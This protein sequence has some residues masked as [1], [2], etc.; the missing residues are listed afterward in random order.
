MELDFILALYFKSG[1]VRFIVENRIYLASPT[2]RTFVQLFKDHLFPLTGLQFK[3]GKIIKFMEENQQGPF[4]VL[5]R[6]RIRFKVFALFC[7][8]HV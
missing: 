5:L 2:R 1:R 8:L 3:G 6:I 7:Q 4:N